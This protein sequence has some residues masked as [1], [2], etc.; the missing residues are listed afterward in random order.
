MSFIDIICKNSGSFSS[1]CY[2]YTDNPLILGQMGQCR[3]NIYLYFDLPPEF[4]IRKVESSR[5]ILYKLPVC[6]PN[7]ACRLYSSN[8]YCL[9][10]LTDFFNI[11]SYC[12]SGPQF[13][14][15]Y[16]TCFVDDIQFSYMEIDITPITQVWHNGQFE[17]KG[18]II[19]S[20]GNSL[21]LVFAGHSFK[22]LSMRPML[23]VTY[24]ST[25]QLPLMNQIPCSV[26]I[27]RHF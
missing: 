22:I 18:L 24:E 3:E 5:L 16:E 14:C 15:K 1:N 20:S 21:P 13:D 17:N 19:T 7:K 25:G 10:P 26:E 12:Y 6:I 2:K 4:Y 23:R 9:Y 27:N 8:L 11:Y